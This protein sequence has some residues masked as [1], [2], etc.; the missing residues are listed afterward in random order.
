MFFFGAGSG[1]VFSNMST[2]ASVGLQ[3]QVVIPCQGGCT[4][5]QVCVKGDFFPRLRLGCSFAFGCCNGTCD[6]RRL[7]PRS[8]SNIPHGFLGGRKSFFLTHTLSVFFCRWESPNLE[9]SQP[10]ESH[11]GI[12]SPPS[13]PT[14]LR[15][16]AMLAKRLIHVLCR[17]GSFSFL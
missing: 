11:L 4:C 12:L 14:G 6:S 8:L 9:V 10:W 3:F 2:F 16:L 5:C 13:V 17:A 15:C 1:S 7:N